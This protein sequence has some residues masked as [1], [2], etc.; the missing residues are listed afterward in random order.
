MIDA[1]CQCIGCCPDLLQRLHQCFHQCESAEII[2]SLRILL[3]FFYS[4]HSGIE[5]CSLLVVKA[6]LSSRAPSHYKAFLLFSLP[7]MDVFFPVEMKA[8]RSIIGSNKG[9]V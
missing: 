6:F 8:E 5:L 3:L 9:T 2:V 7:S 1:L 4:N